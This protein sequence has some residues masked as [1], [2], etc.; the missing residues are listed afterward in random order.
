MTPRLGIKDHPSYSTDFA[1]GHMHLFKPLKKQLAD[2]RFATD[3][4]VKQAVT[5]WTQTLDTEFLYA[6]ICHGVTVRQMLK[7]R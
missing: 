7:S 6:R 3:A 2:K 4:E 5:S 1:P